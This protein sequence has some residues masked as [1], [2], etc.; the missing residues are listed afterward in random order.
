[1]QIRDAR[2][3]VLGDYPDVMD[4]VCILAISDPIPNDTVSF[5]KD[6]P[7]DA[8]E[9]I[10]QALIDYAATEEG[11]EVLANDEFY[12]ITGFARVDDSNFDPIRDMINGLG[13]KEEDILN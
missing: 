10:V 2:S 7:A 1:M 5:S 3:S 9:K 12:D 13:L 6:F 8:R 11:L 4:K